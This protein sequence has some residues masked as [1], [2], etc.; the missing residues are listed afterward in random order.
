MAKN[1]RFVSFVRFPS[2]RVGA[3]R[4]AG[5]GWG[6]RAKICR[7]DKNT[8]REYASGLNTYSRPLFDI[9]K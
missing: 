2:R 9:E 8:G 1:D 6:E 5:A 7:A 3:R 4:T